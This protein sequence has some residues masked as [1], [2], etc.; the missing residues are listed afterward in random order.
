MFLLSSHFFRCLFQSYNRLFFEFL[1]LFS[2][3]VMQFE[4]YFFRVLFRTLQEGQQ[5]TLKRRFAAGNGLQTKIMTLTTTLNQVSNQMLLVVAPGTTTL[6]YH[7][8]SNTCAKFLCILCVSCFWFKRQCF[9]ILT[10]HFCVGAVHFLVQVS[11]LHQQKWRRLFLRYCSKWSLSA[12]RKLLSV[13]FKNQC[14]RFFKLFT[15]SLNSLHCCEHANFILP[16]FCSSTSLSLPSSLLLLL[17]SYHSRS[18]THRPVL[19][20]VHPIFP[21]LRATS[22]RLVRKHPRFQIILGLLLE[23]QPTHLLPIVHPP[24]H[25]NPFPTTTRSTDL[26]HLKEELPRLT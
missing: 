10:C 20:S 25:I 16:F 3:L 21:V 19:S 23:H 7:Y 2:I 24:L 11:R 22:A 17:P 1:R 4:L 12:G 6:R 14:T 26:M 15:A 13:P 5:K 18:P 8:L 9:F